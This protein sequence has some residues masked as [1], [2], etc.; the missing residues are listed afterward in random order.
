[1]LARAIEAQ[2]VAQDGVRF[3][4]GA[5]DAAVEAL[6]AL[7]EADTTALAAAVP[8]LKETV[9]LG[10]ESRWATDVTVSSRVVLILSAQGRIVRG[11]PPGNWLSTR[12]RWRVGPPLGDP[13][14]DGDARAELARRWIER[15]GPVDLDDLRWWGGWA[16]RPTKAAL[17]AVGDVDDSTPRD[18]GS[19][20]ALLP[21][22]DPTTMGWKRRDWYLGDLGPR[23]FDRNGNAGPTV[24][25][26]GRIVGAWAQRPTGEV[27]TS[28]LVDVGREGVAAVEAE[29]ARLQ[30]WL[31]AAGAV[32]KPRFQT[33]LAK[34]LAA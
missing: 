19:W 4:R 22:L 23:L 2:G 27:V 14:A 21:A 7:G 34:E 9:K 29:A 3:L 13:I 8:A 15:F 30:A 32:V 6:A 10:G 31:D 28:L 5:E 18:P 25:W 33:P 11:R 26:R 24:W 1:V 17:D 16:V 20:A 12:N